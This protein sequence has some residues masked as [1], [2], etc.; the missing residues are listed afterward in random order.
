MI[1]V[2]LATCNGSKYVLDFLQSLVSQDHPVGELIVSDDYSIDNTIQIVKNFSLVAPFPVRIL[3]NNNKFGVAENF[4]RA[5]LA[6]SGSYIFLA[7]QDDVWYPEKLRTLSQALDRSG[8]IAAFS[9]ADVVDDKLLPLGYTM[10]DRVSFTPFEI[11]KFELGMSFNVL[12]KHRVVTGATFAFNRE[13]LMRAMPIPA[14]FPHDAWFGLMAAS[15]DR[16]LALS[17]PL[18]AYRQHYSNAIGGRRRTFINEARTAF[19]IDR[20]NWYEVELRFWRAV[21]IRLGDHA[22]GSLQEKIT[23]LETRADMHEQRLLRIPVILNELLKGRYRKYA[24]NWGS[25]AIDL[26]VR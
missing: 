19:S 14:G 5:I 13:L 16:L 15:D 11:N 1:S 20:D 17:K 21:A 26:L 22:P 18:I 7:D 8:V 3:R 4:S 2:A 24:R 9:D 12:L 23:H 10:W 6:C 25:V